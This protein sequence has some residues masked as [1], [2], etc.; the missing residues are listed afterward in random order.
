MLDMRDGRR[1]SKALL[2][3]AFMEIRGRHVFVWRVKKGENI[4]P[5]G[6]NSN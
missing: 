6:E 3:A 4:P 1:D 2:A 5:L